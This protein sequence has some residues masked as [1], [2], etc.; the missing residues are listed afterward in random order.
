MESEEDARKR[1]FSERRLT[2][3]GAGQMEGLEALR[4][5][6]GADGGGGAPA[7]APVEAQ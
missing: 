6:Y 7:P 4:Q 2:T 1:R 3:I 5:Q